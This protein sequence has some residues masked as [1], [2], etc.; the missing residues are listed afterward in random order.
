MIEKGSLDRECSPS[1]EE[2][3]GF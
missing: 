1:L 3:L 2:L